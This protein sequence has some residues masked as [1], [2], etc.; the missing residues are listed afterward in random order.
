MDDHVK[1]TAIATT[2]WPRYICFAYHN[3]SLETDE[4]ELT[5]CTRRAAVEPSTER[6][7]ARRSGAGGLAMASV[8]R[9]VTG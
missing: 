1:G 4:P 8:D 9:Y 6:H 3:A 5:G 7:A 2:S